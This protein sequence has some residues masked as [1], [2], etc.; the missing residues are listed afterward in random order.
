MLVFI[1][2]IKRKQSATSWSELCKLFDRSLRSICN[3][4]S[5]DFKVLVVCNDKPEIEFEHP[6]VEYLEVDFPLPYP[7][8]SAKGD[9]RAKRVFVGLLAVRDLQPS[10][11]MSVDP[12]DCISSKIAEFVSQHQSE[13]GWYVDRGYEYEEGSNKVTVRHKDFYKI[14]GTCNIIN[15]RLF[16]VPEKV[17]AYDDLTGFDRFL[18]G[19][20]LAKGDLAERG[21]PLA[22]LPFPGTI[23]VRDR[24]GESISMQEGLIAKLQRNPKE[25]LRGFKKAALAPFNDQPL[26]PAIQKEFSLFPIC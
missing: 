9:D 18:N 16:K 22:P 8:Y 17:L 5:T 23:F 7:S 26:T 19:H 6:Q 10:H 25:V 1:V 20:P 2:P 15:Y 11:V 13:N 14:C 24:V 21:T 3:Q 12:D 4:T